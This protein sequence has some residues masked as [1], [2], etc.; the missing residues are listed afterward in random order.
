MNRDEIDS[1]VEDIMDMCQDK[2][3]EKCGVGIKHVIIHM[4]KDGMS[5]DDI[6]TKIDTLF[7]EGTDNI[8]LAL[9]LYLRDAVLALLEG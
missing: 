2:I 1:F 6:V 8:A 3:I 4:G 5:D 9:G 7:E